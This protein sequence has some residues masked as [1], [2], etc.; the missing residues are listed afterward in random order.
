MDPLRDNSDEDEEDS[1][2][3]LPSDVS[4][5]HHLPPKPSIHIHIREPAFPSNMVCLKASM[6]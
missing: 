3:P 4:P 5:S 1:I 2:L 6:Y